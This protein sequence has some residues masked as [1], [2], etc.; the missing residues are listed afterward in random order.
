MN[1]P[2]LVIFDLDDT[3]A[4][5]KGPVPPPMM[6]ALG[7]LLEKTQV[8]VI[9][10]ARYE[11]FQTQ[12]LQRLDVDPDLLAKLHIMPTCGTRY[13]HWHVDGWE[14]V[15]AEDMTE[16][17]KDAA[18]RVLTEGA[19]SLGYWGTDSHGPRIEDRGSQVTY[20][21]LGQRAPSA[22]KQ[23]WDP[24]GARKEALRRYAQQRLPALEV[25]SGGSTSVDVTRKGIDKAYGVRRLADMLG[26]ALT[27][28]LFIGDRLDEGG[29]DYP[30]KAL[31]VACVAVGGWEETPGVVRRLLDGR[32]PQP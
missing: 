30:V 8:C 16:A 6:S 22:L 25:R 10:G 29:N 21:A 5:S 20:S 3:L 17:E 11:Q 1:L 15:F 19:R 32:G 18:A 26:L 7:Q 23:T 28:M 27:D 12:L 31:G 4:P 13:Y 9:S 2:E 14:Q 24:T